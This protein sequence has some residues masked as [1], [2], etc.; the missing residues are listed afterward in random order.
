MP[1]LRSDSL[2]ISQKKMATLAE[3]CVAFFPSEERMPQ[4]DWTELVVTV[5]ALNKS[6]VTLWHANF[7]SVGEVGT[8]GCSYI[9]DIINKTTVKQLGKGRTLL[10]DHDNLF[11]RSFCKGEIMKKQLLVA[12]ATGC[13]IALTIAA[14]AR[15]QL[16]G[17]SVRATIPFDFIVRGKTLGAGKYEITRFSDSPNGFL[18]RNLDNNHD[19]AMFETEPFEERKIANRTEIV[20]HRYGDSYFFF[21]LLTAG[22]QTGNEVAPSRAERQLR[23]EM[24]SNL[25]PETVSVAAVAGP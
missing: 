25:Q 24:A 18:I 3:Q 19:K 21:E 14:P 23:S 4:G 1:A 22:E 13:L 10:L 8:H 12:L 16:P 7:K 9:I 11:R 15:A 17:A 20:F 6:L 5:H 2:S